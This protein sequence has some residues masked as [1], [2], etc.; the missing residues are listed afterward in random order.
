MNGDY[1]FGQ[2]G[3]QLPS[4]RHFN[5]ISPRDMSPQM[6][7]DYFENMLDA[8][9]GTYAFNYSKVDAVLARAELNKTGGSG[10]E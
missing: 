5:F 7:D 9:Y 10:D 4:V 3:S 1:Y 6:V 2:G 8:R